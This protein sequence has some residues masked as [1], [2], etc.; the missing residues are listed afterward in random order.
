MDSIDQE[1]L[2]SLAAAEVATPGAKKG[3]RKRGAD[4]DPD[5]AQKK[6]KAKAKARTN[7]FKVC[8]GCRKKFK[9][10]DCAPNW[11]GCWGCKR[12]VD[13]ISKAAVRQGQK[14]VDFVKEARVDDDKC[15]NM[16]QS[17]LEACPESCDNQAGK[18][19]NWALAKYI[20]RVVSAT[21]VVK[22]KAGEMMWEKLYVEHAMSTRGGR[23]REEDA[24]A[25]WKKWEAA[26][27]HKDPGV[28]YD[29]NGPEGKL[30]VWVHT[31]DT[32]VFRASYTHEHEL[33]CERKPV[34][35][36]S[37]EALLR[38]RNDV[39]SG[40]SSCA[41]A[42]G[43]DTD[44]MAIAQGMVT[45]GTD[46]FAGNDGF[47]MDVCDLV[48]E[49]MDDDGQGEGAGGGGEGAAGEGGE[50][51][52]SPNK[53]ALWIDRD[54]IVSST[55]RSVTTAVNLFEVKARAQ[56]DKQRGVLKET[57]KSDAHFLEIFA[58]EIKVLQ[59]RLEAMSLVIESGD[60]DKIK[61]FVARFTV[62]VGSSPVDD[63]EGVAAQR[64]AVGLSPPCELYAELRPIHFMKEPRA[65]R[66]STTYA[67]NLRV[68]LHSRLLCQDWLV[69]HVSQSPAPGPSLL[70]RN[71]GA[72]SPHMPCPSRVVLSKSMGLAP[73]PR[74][75][76]RSTTPAPSLST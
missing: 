64:V 48:K 9:L 21:A 28:H 33:S 56:L 60:V 63:A 39:L 76:S 52:E 68:A 36:P 17:Y 24:V 46:V 4:D 47:I 11:P 45:N 69:S 2:D 55:V 7:T 53:D 14:Q 50:G 40:H 43:S 65:E 1:F 29:F 3:G 13:N 62:N 42:A 15:Y 51:G 34:H 58:G 66:N 41:G 49:K 19:G 75:T 10:E 71:P 38:M 70:L 6:Q 74:S 59:V 31:A 27:L 22:D 18:R 8:R 37:D 12:A 54:R 44:F 73:A 25:Q 57:L 72:Q 61:E 23:L 67:Y 5:S 35:K 26:A 32:M 16:V 30:R 20:E